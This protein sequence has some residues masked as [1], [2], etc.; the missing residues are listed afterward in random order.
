MLL[1]IM[2]FLLTHPEIEKMA[3]SIS[4]S[5]SFENLFNAY[6][7]VLTDARQR[8]FDLEPIFLKKKQQR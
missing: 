1:Q 7:V 3:I 4:G 6:R 2:G 8:R 5:Q